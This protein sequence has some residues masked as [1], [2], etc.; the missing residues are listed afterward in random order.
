MNADFGA[1][2]L[3]RRQLY[4][5][6]I[7]L[8]IGLTFGRVLL[9]ARWWADNDASRWLTAQALAT[10][11][12]Y[13]IGERIEYPGGE[14]VD[15]G[16]LFVN[17][18]ALSNDV[19]LHPTPVWENPQARGFVPARVK[20]YYSSKPALLPTLMGNLL[21]LL[22]Q[23]TGWTLERDQAAVIRVG[24]VV[25]N[26]LPFLLMLIA[27]TSLIENLGRTDWGRVFAV[28]ALGFGTFLTTFQTSINNHTL[29]AAAVAFTLYFLARPETPGA[30]RLFIA[31]FWAGFAAANELPAAALPALCLLYLLLGRRWVG[32]TA[33]LIGAA[34]PVATELLLN[35]LALGTF[36][37]AYAH[38]GTE[39]YLYP[40]SYW[41]N[42]R[43]IDAA[44]DPKLLY[45]AHL[46][47]GHHGLFALTPIFLLGLV[48]ML[49]AVFTPT[50]MSAPLRSLG[51]M[52]LVL[53]IV[54]VGFYVVKTNNYGGWTVGPRWL[55]WLTPFFILLMLPWLDA[56]AEVR[57]RRGLA[58]ALLAWSAVGVFYNQLNPWYHPWLFNLFRAL[59]AVEY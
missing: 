12:T 24:L 41:T 44:A 30:A 49:Q 32:A 1:P 19:V 31:G 13:A 2:P 38:V 10:A 22:G 7:M 59:G 26:V 48:G 9:V 52:G 54:L 16:L 39:W 21:W 47:I 40:G 17:G 15:R 57:W 53:T 8:A 14:Y 37:P 36:A 11:G 5:L 4:A 43:E 51:R 18:K 58:L 46:L 28:A 50:V 33:F 55:F 45:L 29:A 27:M 6:L 23:A 34:L 35:W 25:F 56:A 42:P 3:R 20:R